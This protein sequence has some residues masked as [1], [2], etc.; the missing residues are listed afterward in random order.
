M[1]KKILTVAAVLAVFAAFSVSA[2]SKKSAAVGLQVGANATAFGAGENLALTFKVSAL[3]CVFAATLDTDN[4][5]VTGVGITADWW[6]KNPRLAG[7]FHY[8][9]GPGFAASVNFANSQYANMFL[10]FRFVVGA[11]IFVIDP[12]ELYLQAAWEPGIYVGSKF[13]Y[14]LT[15]V[16]L[17]L[18]FRFW[19]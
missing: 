13:S 12:L 1:N 6:L 11:N 14:E 2:A 9:Y 4:S 15:Y 16:P 18:G 10:G 7:M 3:P 17:N 19:F 5:S 8:Y